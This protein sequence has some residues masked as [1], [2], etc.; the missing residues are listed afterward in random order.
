MFPIHIVGIYHTSSI[1]LIHRLTQG[2]QMSAL[3]K[4]MDTGA[5]D[6]I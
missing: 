5:H 1:I 4:T 3:G 6:R 2:R